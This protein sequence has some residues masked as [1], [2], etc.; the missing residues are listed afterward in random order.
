MARYTG[1]ACRLCRREGMKLFLK[2]D[3]CYK[4]KC[5]F[6]TRKGKLPGQ[7]GAGKLKKPTG[8]AVQLREKQKVKRIYGILE[9]QFRIY[10]EKA[11]KKRGVTGHNLLAMLESRLDN[12]VY[13]LG[14]ASSRRTARQMVLHGHILVNGRRVDIPSYLTK[15][16]QSIEL[17]Q[18]SRDIESVKASIETAA[19]RGIPKWLAF[20]PAA[21]K[22]Q[23]VASPTREDVPLDINEQLIVELYSK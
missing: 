21:F 19:G 23:V 13:R 12:V 11:E 1:A 4:E 16:G 17:R 22:G 9:K 8:Y 7:H 18:A 3:R 6:E 2:G 14:M 5:S 10:F 15:A 20:D